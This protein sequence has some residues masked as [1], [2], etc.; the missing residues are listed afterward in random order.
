M[1]GVVCLVVAVLGFGLATSSLGALTGA[2]GFTAGAWVISSTVV[3]LKGK[4]LSLILLKK[5]QLLKRMDT[6][7]RVRTD[8]TCRME[9]VLLQIT[10]VLAKSPCV[11]D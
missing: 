4:S 9:L 6:R 5:A 2:F 8:E 3:D 11:G 7:R 10:A 1:G